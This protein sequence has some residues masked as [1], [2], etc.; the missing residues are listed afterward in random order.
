MSEALVAGALNVV[1]AGRL[2]LDKL[3]M[4]FL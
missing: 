2:H 1:S 3:T 4:P